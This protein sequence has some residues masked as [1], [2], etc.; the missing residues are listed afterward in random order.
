M[1]ILVDSQAKLK[2][3]LAVCGHFRVNLKE[4]E[5]HFNI[6][7]DNFAVHL[8]VEDQVERVGDG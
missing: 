5:Y 6:K 7:I 4:M 8:Q 2:L 3:N 1:A